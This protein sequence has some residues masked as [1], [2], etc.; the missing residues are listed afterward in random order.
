VA[1]G[2]R[3]CCGSTVVKLNG[4]GRVVLTHM[5]ERELDGGSQPLR[6]EARFGRVHGVPLVARRAV[7]TGLYGRRHIA[8]R[9]RPPCSRSLG[10][11][12]CFCQG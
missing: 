6:V 11:G 7:D 3:R 9:V 12:H 5:V 10:T 2:G 1:D 4:G 8:P